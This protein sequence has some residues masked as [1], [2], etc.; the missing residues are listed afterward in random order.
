M[1]LANGCRLTHSSEPLN[2]TP[3]SHNLPLV[4]PPP[5]LLSLLPPELVDCI[6][7][8][9]LVRAHTHP[10]TPKNKTGL[11][12]LRLLRHRTKS[13]AELALSSVYGWDVEPNI[14]ECWKVARK[15]EDFGVDR[16]RTY[17]K[18]VMKLYLQDQKS[19]ATYIAG[20]ALTA[21]VV[22]VQPSGLATVA[23]RV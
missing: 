6:L 1:T 21:P 10:T 14:Y 5:P 18:Q 20:D 3:I 13:K 2:P 23:T 9:H 22:G 19:I 12:A 17:S 15:V 7:D 11:K 4:P 16:F 8:T